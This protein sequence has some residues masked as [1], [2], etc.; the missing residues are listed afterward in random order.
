M[1][2]QITIIG[3]G[4]IGASIGMALGENKTTARRV[5]FDRDPA[6]ANAALTLGV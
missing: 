1:T 4:Q 5:G 2:A 6:V 3:L